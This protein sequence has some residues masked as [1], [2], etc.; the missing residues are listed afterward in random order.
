MKKLLSILLLTAI[1]L[2]SFAGSRKDKE[3]I[4]VKL[5]YN[6]PLRVLDIRVSLERTVYTKGIFAPYAEKYLGVSAEELITQDSESWAL[7]S[8]RLDSHK[9]IDPLALFNIEM[10]NS[11]QA[12]KLSL[13]PDGN[14][15]AFNADIKEKRIEKASTFINH[16]SA[17]VKNIVLERFALDKPFK[18]VEDTAVFIT[19]ENGEAAQHSKVK[20]KRIAKTIEQKAADAAHIIFKLR[21]RRFKILT[22]NYSQLPKDGQSYKEIIKQ[23]NALEQSYLELFFGKEDHFTQTQTFSVTPSKG[24]SSIVVTRYSETEG[25]AAKGNISA[26][27]I[28]VEIKNITVDKNT[29]SPQLSEKSEEPLNYLHYRVAARAD[30]EI[31]NG[32]KLIGRKSMIIPQLGYIAKISTDVLVGEKMSIEFHPLLGSIKSIYL[33]K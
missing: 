7:K 4:K 21:K 33:K 29:P 13:S 3:D 10:T 2:S 1:V 9:Q 24:S 31:M 32:K 5:N 19:E 15:L 17:Q 26:Q 30:I 23:L 16:Q 18:V 8:V 25:F 14:L 11:Y 12:L 27:P 22:C 6:L 20:G 28:I